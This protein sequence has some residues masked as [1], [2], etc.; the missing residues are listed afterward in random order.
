M[1]KYK[2]LSEESQ[3]D[4][5]QYMVDE[6]ADINSL[7]KDEPGSVAIVAATSDVYILNNKKQWIKL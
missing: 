1:A 5:H 6:T 7:P 2:V 3:F 4:T